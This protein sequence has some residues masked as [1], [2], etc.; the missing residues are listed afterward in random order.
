[1]TGM[2]DSVARTEPHSRGEVA[3]KSKHRNGRASPTIA[4]GNDIAQ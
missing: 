4:P 1:M 2:H 3:V